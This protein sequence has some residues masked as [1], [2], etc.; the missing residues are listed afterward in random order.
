MYLHD[1]VQQELERFCHMLWDKFIP[2]FVKH[3]LKSINTHKG[4]I[5]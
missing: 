3:Q 4:L 2:T 5:L 1:N